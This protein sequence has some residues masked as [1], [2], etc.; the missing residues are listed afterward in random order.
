M[1]DTICGCG[2][3]YGGLDVHSLNEAFDN[4]LSA[5]DELNA[6]NE[7]LI[8][9]RMNRHC[10]DSD[11]SELE[12]EVYYAIIEMDAEANRLNYLYNAAVKHL[13]CIEREIDSL[14]LFPLEI[15]K[16]IASFA[17]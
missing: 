1:G 6:K 13:V 16:G 11:E 8:N 3:V 4:C 14:N 15:S 17:V 2:Y 10:P 7:E 9:S 12:G 5:I